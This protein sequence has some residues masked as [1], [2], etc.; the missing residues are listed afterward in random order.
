MPHQE[1]LAALQMGKIEEA[2]GNLVKAEKL[3]DSII[4]SKDLS[5][6]LLQ[7]EIEVMYKAYYRKLVMNSHHK[8]KVR[9]L[10]PRMIEFFH[11]EKEFR[12]EMYYTVG[13]VYFEVGEKESSLDILTRYLKEFPHGEYATQAC[14]MM[15][16]I[17]HEALNQP[18]KAIDYYLECLSAIDTKDKSVVAFQLS[19]CYL[20]TGQLEKA[21]EAM[22]TYISTNSNMLNALKEIKERR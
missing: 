2:Q 13:R 7:Q 6:E 1:R 16:T 3:Y 22:E 19:D 18:E 11:K 20:L 14:L 12:E 21:K 5:T 9:E 8:G 4:A 15:A 10:A 17:Y